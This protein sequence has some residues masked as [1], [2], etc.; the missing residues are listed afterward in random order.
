M[1]NNLNTIL[2]LL[3]RELKFLENGGYKRSLER[4]WRPP[5]IFE[6]SPSCQNH[7]DHIR[8]TR[9]LDCW[10]IQFVPSDLQLEQIPC[11]FVPLTALVHEFFVAFTLRPS[12]QKKWGS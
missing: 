1:Q 8:Q 11:R 7:L 4:P 10:L 6:Q 2:N 5:Y 9:C 3:K 12:D